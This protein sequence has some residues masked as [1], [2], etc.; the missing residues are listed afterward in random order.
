MF[1]WRLILCPPARGSHPATFRCSTR[2]TLP[3]ADQ[4]LPMASCPSLLDAQEVESALM[5]CAEQAYLEAKRAWCAFLCRKLLH[6]PATWVD[7]SMPP[8][9]CQLTSGPSNCFQVKAFA[10][11]ANFCVSFNSFNAVPQTLA[12]TPLFP[13]HR[14]DQLIVCE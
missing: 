2:G 14:C 8:P 7:D 9:L 13:L 5:S 3:P 10:A 6:C 1:A 12:R 11:C 4:C